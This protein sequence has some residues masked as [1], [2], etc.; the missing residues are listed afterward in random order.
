LINA[1]NER[2]GDKVRA[3]AL[4]ISYLKDTVAPDYDLIL[5]RIS[6]EVPFYRTML[7]AAVGRGVQVINNPFWCAADDKYFNNIVA[8]SAG[9][10]VPRTIVVPHKQHPPNTQSTSFRNLEFVDWDAVFSYLGFPIFL[11]P[12][13]GGGW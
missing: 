11:K 13:Y 2:E 10:A 1:I 7:K 8:L 3:S 4:E 9:V 6:H 5:D 12:A